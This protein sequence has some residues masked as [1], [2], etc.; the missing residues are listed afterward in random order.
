[1]RQNNI[2]CALVAGI[3]LAGAAHEASAQ[4]DKSAL[5]KDKTVTIMV[6]AAPGGGLDTYARL[7]SRHLQKHIP[8]RWRRCGAQHLFDR[9]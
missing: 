3:L 8:G 6:G 4:G 7:I 1:M 5:F 2:H 9:A